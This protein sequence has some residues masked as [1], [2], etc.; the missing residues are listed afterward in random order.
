MLSREKLEV[1]GEDAPRR[2]SATAVWQI[3][4]EPHIHTLRLPANLFRMNTDFT[5]SQ[6]V[7]ESAGENLP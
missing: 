5:S 3:Y 4:D 7:A 1:S 6:A 2:F